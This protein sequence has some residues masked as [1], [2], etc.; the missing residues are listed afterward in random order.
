M[1]GKGWKWLETVWAGLKR[2]LID[3]KG[4][5]WFWMTKNVIHSDDKLQVFF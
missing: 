1:A 4:I 3:E 2:L 5:Q